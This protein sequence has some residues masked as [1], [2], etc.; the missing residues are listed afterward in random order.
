L[1][2]KEID[3]AQVKDELFGQVGVALD[4]SAEFACVDGIDVTH[5]GYRCAGRRRVANSE[6]RPTT[7][8]QLVR[9]RGVRAVHQQGPHSGHPESP[10]VSTQGSS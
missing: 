2:A 5:H 8:L 6:G 4:E 10:K 1:A 9:G 7:M 3:R